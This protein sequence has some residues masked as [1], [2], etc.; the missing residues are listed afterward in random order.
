MSELLIAR[1]I[2]Q[3]HASAAVDKLVGR[4]IARDQVALQFNESVGRSAASAS[5]PTT[6][7][8]RLAHRQRDD[9]ASRSPQ[10]P[11]P[12]E[13]GRASL[14]VALPAH[15]QPRQ[16]EQWLREAGARSLEWSTQPLPQEADGFWPAQGE[17][18][19]LDVQRA[20]R[21]I[22]SARDR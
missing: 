3:F 15:M 18:S 20:R 17:G 19:A 14:R 5:A 10:Q 4:G 16:L 12:C 11:H 13:R 9:H 1:F 8:S 7:V 21:A 22:P 6:V 2:D